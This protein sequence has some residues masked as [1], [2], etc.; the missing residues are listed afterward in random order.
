MR[1]ARDVCERFERPR[2]RCVARIAF[3]AHANRACHRRAIR[4]QFIGLVPEC[5]CQRRNVANRK[6]GA[7]AAADDQI[8]RAADRIAHDGRYAARHRFVDDE[9]PRLTTV[10]WQ[11]DHVGRGIGRR[12]FGLISKTREVDRRASGPRLLLQS[13]VQWARPDNEAT[14]IGAS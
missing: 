3:E 7:G 2:D 13:G 12:H 1:N 6:D 8:V 5:R 14:D 4:H 9:P 10:R 11:H